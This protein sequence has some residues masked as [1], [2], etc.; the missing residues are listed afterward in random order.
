VVLVLWIYE[1]FPQVLDMT[2]GKTLKV[3]RIL[4]D[5]TQLQMANML[6]ISQQ[7]YSKL[8]RHEWIDNKTIDEILEKL[9]CTREELDSIKRVMSDKSQNEGL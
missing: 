6:S 1:L 7:A 8:E 4:R 9:N 5:L 2:S 3:I